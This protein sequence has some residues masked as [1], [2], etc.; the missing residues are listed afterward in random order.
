MFI[1]ED[2]PIHFF[3]WNSVFYFIITESFLSILLIWKQHSSW[4]KKLFLTYIEKVYVTLFNSI[5]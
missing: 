2:F 5:T 3:K 1:L 4:A